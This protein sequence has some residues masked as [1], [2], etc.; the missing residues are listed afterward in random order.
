MCKNYAF[1]SVNAKAQNVFQIPQVYQVLGGHSL[2]FWLS[3]QMPFAFANN[4]LG[5][6]IE[7]HREVEK[8]ITCHFRDLVEVHHKCWKNIMK[9]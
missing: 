9:C 8:N 4:A 3:F 5:S 6:E 2:L 7:K 1:I